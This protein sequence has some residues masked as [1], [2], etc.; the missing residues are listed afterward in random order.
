MCPYIVLVKNII[1]MQSLILWQK[2]LDEDAY[3]I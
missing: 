2:E 3:D 1:L